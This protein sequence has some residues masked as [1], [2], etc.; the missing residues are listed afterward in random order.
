MSGQTDGKACVSKEII[1]AVDNENNKIIY[2]E[3]EGDLLQN[4]KSFKFILQVTPQKNGSVAHWTLEYE[5]LKDHI[6]DPHTMMEMVIELSKGID[7]HLDA[8]QK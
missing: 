2:K 7:A 1:E 6:P 4:Y 5:K 8:D 3:I